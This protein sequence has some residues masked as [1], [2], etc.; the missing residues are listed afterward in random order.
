LEKLLSNYLKNQ[1]LNEEDLTKSNLL[2]VIFLGIRKMVY[3]LLIKTD[4]DEFLGY[5]KYKSNN[6]IHIYFIIKSL[7]SICLH[8]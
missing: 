8:I 3:E 2:E 7:F 4:F 6:N 1:E 5:E